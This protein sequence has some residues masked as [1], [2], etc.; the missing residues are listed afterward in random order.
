MG[1]VIYGFYLSQFQF[2]LIGKDIA[3]QNVFYNYKL[4]Q[5]IYTQMS[6]GSG[7]Y[8]SIA[9]EHRRTQSKFVLF[10]D[11]N[12]ATILDQDRYLTNTGQLFGAKILTDT[13]AYTVYSPTDKNS[14]NYYDLAY[15]KNNS[16]D[17]L[18]IDHLNTSFEGISHADGVDALNL[19]T[20]AYK[21]GANKKISTIWSLIFYPFNP[22]LSLL[23]LY[24]DPVDELKLFDQKSLTQK[25]NLHLSSE[26]TARA[27]PVT[28]WLLK[29]PSYENVF[30]MA[31][32]R[33]LVT[34][35]LT[36]NMSIDKYPLF[37]ALKRGS[38]YI[39]IDTLGDSTGFET[40]IVTDKK[41]EYIFMGD[42]HTLRPNMRLV[43]RLPREP[44]THHEVILYKNGQR[45]DHR[46][47]SFGDF[48]ITSSGVYRLQ[49]RLETVLPFP[50]ADNKWL[51][52]IFTN[53]FY[54]R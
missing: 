2:N 28:N 43:F 7:T 1:Y 41:N 40:Y 3:G 19:K 48:P 23:R 45:I 37:D 13:A 30:N 11:L 53:N 22:R 4:H 29:F 36:T 34:S 44:N 16:K 46:N 31:S 10:T 49:V 35:E 12:P 20:M 51:T 9:E 33:V 42:E 27:V 25:V 5:N 52:W 6:I 38:F 18:I 54:I 26:V 32:Q 47:T 17:Y 24:R 50:D 39:S 15:L 21:V 14:A 8:S